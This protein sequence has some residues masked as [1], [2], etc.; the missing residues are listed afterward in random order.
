MTALLVRIP[1]RLSRAMAV[2]GLVSIF[3]L[4]GSL[5]LA[6]ADDPAADLSPDPTVEPSPAPSADPG[7]SPVAAS[8]IP[9]PASAVQAT[10]PPVILPVNGGVTEPSVSIAVQGG[11]NQPSVSIPVQAGG[12]RPSIVH[13]AESLITSPIQTAISGRATVM[14]DFQ[15]RPWLVALVL[16]L[17]ISIL[18]MLAAGFRAKRQ[19]ARI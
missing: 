16:G 9:D 8:A 13:W 6:M 18:A 5:T 10:T 15:P 3:A 1:S 11:A 19:L 14:A 17:A 12:N 7:P 2:A 4:A